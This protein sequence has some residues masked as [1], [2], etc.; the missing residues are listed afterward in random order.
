MNIVNKI[1]F[2]ILLLIFTSNVFS[3]SIYDTQFHHI[4]M[5]T[6]N[7]SKTKL[8]A[9]K[10]I[11]IKSFLN[12]LDKTL[13]SENKNYFLKKV[14]YEKNIDNFIQNIIINNELITKKK[15]I[16]D[17]KINFNKK[18][19]INLFRNNLV[20]Y[21]DVFSNPF[22]IISSYTEKFDNSGL[23]NENIIYDNV[24]FDLFKS[25]NNL[26]NLTIPELTPNDR[27]ILPYKKIIDEDNISLSKIANKYNVENII[28]V[29]INKKDNN[30]LDIKLI[31][32]STTLNNFFLIGNLNS[33]K[34]KNLHESIFLYLNDWWKNKYLIDNS[35]KNELICQIQSTSFSDLINIKSKIVNLSQ[36]KSIN[37]II[38]S[39]NHNTEKIKYFGE[40]TIFAKNL[41]LE[42]INIIVN[43]DCIIS[44]M[45]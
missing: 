16:A 4:D 20:N 12:I 15:Y 37:P 9:I 25:K 21:S 42:K 1:I 13:T 43:D 6:K 11:K 41:S 3:K 2:F 23:T 18:K 10:T 30:Y 35:Q 19:I 17:I 31:Y 5:K 26:I 36:F 14:N 39:Y 44:T 28:L 40:Y 29:K 45:N 7:V 24:K 34:N 22:L 32:Y 27:F 33:I 38:I 8:E